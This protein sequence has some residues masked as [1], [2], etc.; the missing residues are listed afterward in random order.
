MLRLT[1]VLSV[2]A[3][4]L[5]AAASQAQD[6]KQTPKLDPDKVFAKLDANSDGKVTKEEFKKLSE[7]GQGQL[8]GRAELLDKVFDKLDANANGALSKDE[9]TKF[10]ALAK[11]LAGGV[12]AKPQ[13]GIAA[14]KDTNAA[15]KKLDADKD[16]KLTKDEFTKLA[17]QLDLPLLKNRPELLEKIFGRLDADGNGTLTA[18]EFKQLSELSQKL[19]GRIMKGDK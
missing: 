11:R 4:L 1:T 6:A 18:E 9:F 10:G 15:F 17:D 7:I 19:A 2:T 16:S 3:L 14:L 5:A 8:K 13:T 12:A